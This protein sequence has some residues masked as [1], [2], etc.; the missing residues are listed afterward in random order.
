M[1]VAHG[2][3]RAADAAEHAAHDA[4]VDG[5]VLHHQA[6]QRPVQAQQVVGA[7]DEALVRARR[8]SPAGRRYRPRDARHRSRAQR[9][10]PFCGDARRQAAAV[11]GTRVDV[12]GQ[13]RPPLRRLLRPTH[14]DGDGAA[15]GAAAAAA[16]AGAGPAIGRVGVCVAQAAGSRDGARRDRGGRG[17]HRGRRGAQ[18]H[19][20]DLGGRVHRRRLAARGLVR[21][22][23]H[24]HLVAPAVR[25]GA[26]L[27]DETADGLHHRAAQRERE[28]LEGAV[29]ARVLLRGRDAE[30][31]HADAEVRRGVA[32]LANQH[33]APAEGLGAV[34]GA[35]DHDLHHARHDVVVDVDVG[36]HGPVEADLHGRRPREGAARGEGDEP[37]LH[38]HAALG[39]LRRRALEAAQQHAVLRQ[40]QQALQR[41]ERLVEVAHRVRARRH[42]LGGVHERLRR[43]RLDRATHQVGRAVH[44]VAD[45]VRQEPHHLRH[46]ARA[47]RGRQLGALRR[48]LHLGLVVELDE[49]AAQRRRAQERLAVV[50][51]D[52]AVH[53]Q[54]ERRVEAQNHH[55]AGRLRQA[56]A[57]AQRDGAADE[58]GAD[59]ERD[60]DGCEGVVESRPANED[61]DVRKEEVPHQER[62][63]EH[64]VLEAVAFSCLGNGGVAW[65][66]QHPRAGQRAQEGHRV[67]AAL[68][69]RQE[70]EDRL[71]VGER[72]PVYANGRRRSM[73]LDFHQPQQREGRRVDCRRHD[74]VPHV[75]RQPRQHRK[76]S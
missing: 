75:A 29:G 71:L 67:R 76:P 41:L 35:A 74:G 48:L 56:A 16:A 54:R 53:V 58:G 62:R 5:L 23:R 15:T 18:R 42:G 3:E 7:R 31:E 10:D 12:D 37:R 39:R 27:L 66:A 49:G 33:A 45:L 68:R 24:A 32:P 28:V 14:A 21:H 59:P 43:Q 30:R 64:P 51:R 70:A 50:V 19:L 13:V 38:V 46:D 52:D 11:Q 1:A 65:I 25:H 36:R 8:R 4:H 63:R 40:P 69:D 20:G 72:E 44:R 17:A 55:Q 61:K 9:R 57:E 60:G 73:R 22:G 6:V 34:R 2:V 47:R 26:A